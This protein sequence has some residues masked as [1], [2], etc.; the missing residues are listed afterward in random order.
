M[1]YLYLHGFASGPQSAK[2]KYLR[3]RF[4]GL[5]LDLI[6]PDLN[7]PEFRSL[8]LSRQIAQVETL[9]DD[10]PVTLLGSS[11]GGLTCAWLAQ[12]N[13]QVQRLVLLAPAFDFARRYR[14]LIGPEELERWR[15]Q[16]TRQFHHWQ[17]NEPQPL[18]YGFVTDLDRWD[19]AQLRRSLP[20]LIL[21]GHGDEVIPL[22][23]SRTYAAERPWVRLE[24]L[25]SDHGMGNVVSGIW[26]RTRQFLDLEGDR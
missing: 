23:S 21:H 10:G 9:L 14:E 2:A 19:E 24:A 3:Q 11:F 13:P 1:Q 15:Q 4:A 8:S 12:R 26:R 7:E 16:G 6:C 18:D 20:T 17:A 5:G 25:D 22:Q